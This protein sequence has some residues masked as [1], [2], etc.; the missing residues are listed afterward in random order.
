MQTSFSLAPM[1]LHALEKTL[2]CSS[3]KQVPFPEN[4]GRWSLNLGRRVVV[5]VQFKQDGTCHGVLFLS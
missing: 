3:T 4:L 5:G 2:R 1:L